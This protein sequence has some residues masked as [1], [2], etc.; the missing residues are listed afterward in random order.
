MYR[1]GGCYRKISVFP[2]LYRQT[3]KSTDYRQVS[4]SEACRRM[5]L[6]RWD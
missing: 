4:F 5:F 2:S 3:Q 6:C 1:W